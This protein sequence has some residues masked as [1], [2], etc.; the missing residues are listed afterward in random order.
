[1]KRSGEGCKAST[2]AWIVEYSLKRHQDIKDVGWPGSGLAVVLLIEIIF[3]E[4]SSWEALSI[5]F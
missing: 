5:S 1:V 2:S 3:R 4:P